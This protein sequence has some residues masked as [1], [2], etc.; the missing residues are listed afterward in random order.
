MALM[1]WCYLRIYKRNRSQASSHTALFGILVG[2]GCFSIFARL[3]SGPYYFP[4]YSPATGGPTCQK[5]S[6]A[7]DVSIGLSPKTNPKQYRENVVV[8]R[9]D[10]PSLST[11]SLSGQKQ[12]KTTG[13]ASSKLCEKKPKQP[14]LSK[15]NLKEAS[16]SNNPLPHTP[17]C[18]WRD[19]WPFSTSSSGGGRLCLIFDDHI[20]IILVPIFSK[21][22]VQCTRYE[23]RYGKF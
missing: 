17:R 14:S 12:T 9:R 19:L 15:H 8:M 13:A 20:R 3:R 2:W 4:S 23:T 5:T 16:I 18:N 10:Q 6:D 22:R 7:K 21:R 11:H 1:I